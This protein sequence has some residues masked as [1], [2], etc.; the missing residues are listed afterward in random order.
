MVHYV[1]MFVFVF[2][3]ILNKNRH[4][5]IFKTSC[6]FGIYLDNIYLD[7]W[8]RRLEIVLSAKYVSY[9]YFSSVDNPIV[10][11]ISVLND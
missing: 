6:V 5:L 2:Y 10:C 1:Q 8:K 4:S 7:L 11:H 9:D 3:I